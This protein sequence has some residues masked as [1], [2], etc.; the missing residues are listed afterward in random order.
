MLPSTL[1]AI[2]VTG[3]G[4]LTWAIPLVIFLAVLFW[5]MI[6]LIRRFPE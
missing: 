2:T 4:V 3:E 6:D 5:H 1:V